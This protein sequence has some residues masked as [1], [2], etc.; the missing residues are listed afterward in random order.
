MDLRPS[1]ARTSAL[2]L[3]FQRS[4]LG[5]VISGPPTATKIKLLLYGFLGYLSEGSCATT[6]I[7]V[8][9]CG[10]RAVRTRIAGPWQFILQKPKPNG[11]TTGASFSFPAGGPLGICRR[12]ACTL[13]AG[14]LALGLRKVA[15]SYASIALGTALAM[16]LLRATRTR[17]LYY[18]ININPY[19]LQYKAYLSS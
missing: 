17:A 1:G 2:S 19:L 15:E 10:L 7:S 16:Q 14:T 11:V 8:D 13:L 18:S 12:C 6:P 3:S 4:G 9:A 5:R